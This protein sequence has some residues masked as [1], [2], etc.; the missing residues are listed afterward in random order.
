MLWKE[1]I[2]WFILFCFDV[3]KET[4]KIRMRVS[5]VASKWKWNEHILKLEINLPGGVGPNRSASPVGDISCV[6]NVRA[7]VAAVFSGGCVARQ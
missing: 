7:I 4:E 6:G 5:G 3:Q 1:I 2:K